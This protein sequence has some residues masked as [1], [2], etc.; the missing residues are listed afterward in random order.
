M[1][2]DVTL[3]PMVKGLNSNMMVE[4]MSKWSLILCGVREMGE[5][6]AGTMA[7]NSVTFLA[8]SSSFLAV[9]KLHGL[10]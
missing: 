6:E 9:I 8:I 7:A 10:M 3:P 1:T 2:G 4:L 5:G